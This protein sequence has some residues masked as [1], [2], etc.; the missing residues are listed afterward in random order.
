M[1]QPKEKVKYRQM[2]EKGALDG[3][4]FLPFFGMKSERWFAL[5]VVAPP[6]EV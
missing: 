4:P 1:V 3:A 5:V 6:G 2:K